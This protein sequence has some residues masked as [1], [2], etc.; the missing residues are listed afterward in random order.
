VIINSGY[1][2]NS[3]DIKL[4]V[5]GNPGSI[6]FLTPI[7][8]SGIKIGSSTTTIKTTIDMSGNINT[9]GNVLATK[10]GIGTTSP[11]ANLSLG[12]SLSNN[13]LAVYETTDGVSSLGFGVKQ[14]EFASY[15]NGTSDHFSFYNNKSL[16][17]ANE[18]M[19]I[20]G[21]GKV[22]IGTSTFS[23]DALLVV[24][25]KISAQSLDV[26]GTW[27][28]VANSNDIFYSD[29]KVAIGTSDFS[30]SAKLNVG[31]DVKANRFF[32]DGTQLT[33][34]WAKDAVTNNIS[35]NQGA[36]NI[37][38]AN[39]GSLE[40]SNSLNGTNYM[41]FHALRNPGTHDWTFSTD[42]Q[43]STGN[44]GS[45]IMSDNNGDVNV[46]CVQSAG[47]NSNTL[48][49]ATVSN[50]LAIK[51]A[52]RSDVT[53]GNHKVLLV[54][55]KIETPELETKLVAANELRT[56]KLNLKVDNVADYVFDKNYKL[57]TLKEVEKYVNQN[58]H[59]PD[60]PSAKELQANGMDVAN[61]NNLLLQKIEEISLYMIE[62]NKRI[63]A[64]E[65]ENQK[66]REKQNQ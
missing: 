59:L 36:V 6:Y 40:G 21:S 32:G 27:G 13:K 31:G 29:G 28:K 5:P 30:S 22:G 23:G 64:L 7:S 38:K 25:G 18:I 3:G 34:L 39:I 12:S 42:A 41:G 65:L 4:Q 2:I 37:G 57:R 43:N 54:Y 53:G 17:S 49:D 66:L 33:G 44:A 52:S 1:G 62:Q 47:T 55:G 58:K 46:F 16:N 15:L 56:D 11:L 24:N 63:E 20:D 48:S 10:V 35:Y 9:Q 61:M 8:G 51:I 60:M 14:N 19:R 26:P 50:N 45:I